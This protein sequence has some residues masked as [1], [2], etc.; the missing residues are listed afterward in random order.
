MSCNFCDK[1]FVYNFTFNRPP[2]PRMVAAGGVRTM[3]NPL[4]NFPPN[5]NNQALGSPPLAMWPLQPHVTRTGKI[6]IPDFI[7]MSL[8]C[9]SDFASNIFRKIKWYLNIVFCVSAKCSLHRNVHCTAW[10]LYQLSKNLCK[11]LQCHEKAPTRA[12]SL[13]RVSILAF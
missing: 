10:R 13:V 7:S 8:F 1:I 6:K 11:D 5:Y 2:P 12:F 4:A 3:S 9:E